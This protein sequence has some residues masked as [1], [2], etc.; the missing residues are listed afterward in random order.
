MKYLKTFKI[1]EAKLP[2][3]HIRKNAIK[4]MKPGDVGYTVPW[5]V[6]VNQD[7]D[8]FINGSFTIGEKGGTSCLK[9]KMIKN[10]LIAYISDL[11]KDYQNYEKEDIDSDSLQELIEIIGFD[12]TISHTLEN[13]E[14][15]LQ[16][17]LD[18][19]DYK[20]AAII[21]DKIAKRK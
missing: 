20:Q 5:A 9:V 4:H 7:G 14:K 18:I 8:C 3:S 1:F 21:R 16:N 17:A 6:K 11:P 13:L 19:E 15:E 12:D 2:D 10:G